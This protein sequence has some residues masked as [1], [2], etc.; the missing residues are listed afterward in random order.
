MSRCSPR[1]TPT[2]SPTGRGR[3]WSWSTSVTRWTTRGSTGCPPRARRGGHLLVAELRGRDSEGS[4]EAARLEAAPAGHAVGHVRAVFLF[5]YAG[6]HYVERLRW[7]RSLS[8]ALTGIT[9]G[10]VGVDEVGGPHSVAAA[11]RVVKDLCASSVVGAHRVQALVVPL[12]CSGPT[13]P[14]EFDDRSGGGVDVGEPL[15][16]GEARVTRVADA[17]GGG[18]RV[19]RGQRRGRGNGDREG[20]EQGRRGGGPCSHNRVPF[21]VRPG[22]LLPGRAVSL[23]DKCKGS[24]LSNSL[25]Q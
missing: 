10:D 12:A 21:R 19:V 6:G 1:S 25:T 3:H 13:A 14:A 11:E 16:N 8:A 17:A 24:I 18:R 9:A 4:R 5:I 22:R 2:C 7:N 20:G 23:P 15:A